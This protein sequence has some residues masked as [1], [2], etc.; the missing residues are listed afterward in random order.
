[1]VPLSVLYDFFLLEPKSKFFDYLIYTK[2]AIIPLT[3]ENGVLLFDLFEVLEVL[4]STEHLG[5]YL[6]R[7]AIDSNYRTIGELTKIFH[8]SESTLENA[9]DSNLI[10]T[11]QTYLNK[12]LGECVIYEDK[13]KF[14]RKLIKTDSEKNRKYLFKKKVKDRIKFDRLFSTSGYIKIN[15]FESSQDTL[16]KL[17]IKSKPTYLNITEEVVS[18]IRVYNLSKL[19]VTVIR[20]NSA[21]WLTLVHEDTETFK[22]IMKN[23]DL[24]DFNYSVD[25]SLIKK[26]YRYYQENGGLLFDVSENQVSLLKIN[27]KGLLMRMI[28]VDKKL[29][30]FEEEELWANELDSS[31]FPINRKETLKWLETT[32]VGISISQNIIWNVL[33]GFT[34]LIYL[35]ILEDTEMLIYREEYSG[36]IYKDHDT[37]ESLYLISGDTE[38]GAL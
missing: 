2:K 11:M 36:T 34:C 13:Y 32:T 20:F 3:K 31:T 29:H 7:L 24:T 27:K 1:M 19:S 5:R 25:M 35:V 9:I 17:T 12:E 18:K 23:K 22:S 10:D 26:F 33:T 15:Q 4:T 37:I 16:S 28:E 14:L 38:E 6:K 8:T 30:R 21:Q